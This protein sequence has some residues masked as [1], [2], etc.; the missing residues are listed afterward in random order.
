MCQNPGNQK[1]LN[2]AEDFQNFLKRKK[3]KFLIQIKKILITTTNQINSYNY[4]VNEY[5]NEPR[6]GQKLSVPHCQSSVGVS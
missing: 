6:D 3:K 1:S 4:L 5:E 2:Q